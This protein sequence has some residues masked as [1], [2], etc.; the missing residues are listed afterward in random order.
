[1]KM[2]LW[3]FLHNRTV[4]DLATP[5]LKSGRYRIPP[6]NGSRPFSD[7]ISDFDEKHK[8]VMSSSVQNTKSFSGENY[9]DE[10][11]ID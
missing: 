7:D 6:L 1:M 3:A 11:A 2:Q 8:D 9:Y 4:D 10:F 5:N